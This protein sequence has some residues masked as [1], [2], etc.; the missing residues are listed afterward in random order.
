MTW[1]WD[2]AWHVTHNGG[3]IAMGPLAIFV[4]CGPIDEMPGWAW[5]LVPIVGIAG[6]VYAWRDYDRLH[7]RR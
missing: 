5:L 3:T 2:R 1:N 4:I 7:R 6:A